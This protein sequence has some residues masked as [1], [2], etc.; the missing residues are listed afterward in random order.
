VPHYWIVDA[1]ARTLE[2]FSLESGR[3]VLA[4]SYD[5]HACAPISPFDAIEI[6]IGRLFLPRSEP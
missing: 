2:A 3:W 5:E 4:G 1:D 6:E